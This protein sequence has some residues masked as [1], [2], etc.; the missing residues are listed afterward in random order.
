[1]ENLVLEAKTRDLNTKLKEIRGD[2][3]LPAVVYGKGEENL[4]I[5]FDYQKFRKVFQK[6]GHSVLIDLSIDGAKP[7]EVLIHHL[8]Y[9][10]VSGNI[11]HVDFK[12]ITR[13]VEI[14]T[15]IP[16]E[17]EGV[18]EAVKT[19]GG[20]FVKNKEFLHVKCLPR[21]LVHNFTADLTLLKDFN[22]KITVADLDIPS[23]IK[24][25]NDLEEV[26]ATV[27]APRSAIESSQESEAVEAK[28]EEKAES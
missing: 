5:E 1:M 17:F 19:L 10:P 9:A 14:S 4:F 16:I 8:D 24:V 26:V 28:T 23:T 12:K 21:N 20:I 25:L 7:I 2:S 3:R 15:E 11:I 6:G 27:T 13:G 18:S 22:S